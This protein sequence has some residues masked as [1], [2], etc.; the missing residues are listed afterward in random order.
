MKTTRPYKDKP[1]L[2]LKT[3][4]WSERYLL[5]LCSQMEV[6]TSHP[7][8]TE[9]VLIPMIEKAKNIKLRRV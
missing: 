6:D 1:W 7:E 9:K 4:S 3:P 2:V 5:G 8:W